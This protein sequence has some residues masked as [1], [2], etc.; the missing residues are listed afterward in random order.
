MTSTKFIPET[1]SWRHFIATCVGAPASPSSVVPAEKVKIGDGDHKTVLII[2]AFRLNF[3]ELGSEP[4]SFLFIIYFS[5]LLP[6]FS[7]IK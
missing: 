4:G 3:D 6:L 5:L 2:E 1:L 7:N